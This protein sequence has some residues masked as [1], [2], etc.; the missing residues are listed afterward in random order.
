[1]DAKFELHPQTY[2]WM[3]HLFNRIRKVLGLN[4]KFHGDPELLEEGE[5]FVFNHFSRIETFL[6][7]WV[8]FNETGA[9]C[10]S[11]ASA[12]LFKS[13]D[14]FASFLWKVGAIPT[15]H[16][17]L[18]PVLVAEVMRGKKIIIFPEG[19]MVKDRKV[20]NEKGK[21]RVYSRSSK[22]VR[23][24]H[25]GAAVLANAVS[26]VK[27]SILLSEKK[28]DWSRIDDWVK[29]LGAESRT[30]LLY[31]A[32]KRTNIV[33]CNITF[34]PLHTDEGFFLR[35]KKLFNKDLSKRAREELI[36]ES[37]IL[38]KHTDMD[39]RPCQPIYVS[40]FMS[41]WEKKV[42]RLIAKRINS[43]HDLYALDD[44]SN[45]QLAKF[46]RGVFKQSTEKVRD[47]F[48]AEIY[49]AITIN[50]NHL[51][52]SIIFKLIEE[53]E[54]SIRVSDL[55]LC[56]YVAIKKVQQSP[57]A[58]LH[59]GLKNPKQ[60]RSLSIDG[61]ME[62]VSDNE[63][64]KLLQSAEKQGLIQI[65]EGVV[66][67]LDKL[68]HDYDL[69]TVRL[70]NTLKVYANE[71]AP[72]PAACEA[73][74]AAVSEYKSLTQERQADF[75]LDDEQRNYDWH[76]QYYSK[77]RFDEV[78]VLETATESGRP[79][80]IKGKGSAARTGVLLVH[81]FLASAAEMRPVSDELLSLGFTQYALRLEGHGTSPADLDKQT[82]EDWVKSVNIAYKLLSM[83]VDEIIILG[84]SAG[85]LLSF[86]KAA[87]SPPN[88][89]G[90]IAVNAVMKIQH[91]AM[92][93]VPL[94]HGVSKVVG[95][96]PALENS[97]RYKA[98]KPE[99]P[100][101]NYQSIPVSALYQL[102]QL[103][104]EVTKKLEDV[105][106]PCLLLQSTQDPVIE[107]QS[108]DL[109]QKK[110]T[111]SQVTLVE[112]ESSK[113]GILYENVGDTFSEITTFLMRLVTG[114]KH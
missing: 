18:F 44:V 91:K 85:A 2:E 111:G 88:L 78:N 23:K 81:G 34:F 53:E 22:T 70:K 37:N 12:S 7:H 29:T 26:T 104:D 6:P 64:G 109:A 57:V 73:V 20:Q 95:K 10:R 66:N 79:Y 77:Q 4:I 108:S 92:I 16:S 112:I 100:E 3:I 52:S 105:R 11:I 24:H 47:K 27:E 82:W 31:I 63:L 110:L 80:L 68:Q 25:T 93:F 107:V 15:N 94:M 75:L 103:I 96:I 54:F 35:Q 36:I 113:H 106:V 74:D 76:R 86:Y 33:P 71:M 5:I 59:R 39:M 97:M 45:S 99:H 60:Y 61:Q 42:Q 28:K 58:H 49:G 9:F 1:M 114:R 38:F 43:I 48:M 98:N 89:R 69:D 40:E 32:H 21:F 102:L 87:E 83:Y 67:L 56:L 41:W 90:V 50:V 8:I 55:C 17:E 30:K 65:E 72:V 101:V 51:A 46:I 13:N 62:C 14:M 19:G 84:F